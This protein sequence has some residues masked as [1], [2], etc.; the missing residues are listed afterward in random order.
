MLFV[1]SVI[2][3]RP[4]I[5]PRPIVTL[6]ANKLYLLFIYIA[7]YMLARHDADIGFL[8]GIVLCYF[9]VQY[10]C[11]MAMNSGDP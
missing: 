7:L 2:P 11:G 1:F 10:L 3:I 6:F 9:H 5:L 4:V 8:A